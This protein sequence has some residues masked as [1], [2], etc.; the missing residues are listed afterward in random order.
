MLNARQVIR[1][2]RSSSWLLNS[3]LLF[4]LPQ[5]WAGTGN[6]HPGAPAPGPG[7]I[8][9]S[10]HLAK[11]AWGT[12]AESCRS[13]A[14]QQAPDTAGGRG[15]PTGTTAAQC[16]KCGVWHQGQL[17]ASPARGRVVP[18]SGELVATPRRL[19]CGFWDAQGARHTRAAG[20]DRA[21][22]VGTSRAQ[23]LCLCTTCAASAR[24]CVGACT[25][26]PTTAWQDLDLQCQ[27][28]AHVGLD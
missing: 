21:G 23:D 24:V 4:D 20:P 10:G 1:Q 25:R 3:I 19:S 8:R 9:A 15:V 16:P 14:P 2:G 5:R 11:Q 27:S 13:P 17:A 18:R 26:V 7:L 6:S 28:F 22:L 12:G